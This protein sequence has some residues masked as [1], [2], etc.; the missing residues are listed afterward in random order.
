MTT[1]SNG[2]NPMRYKCDASGCY[3]LKHRPKIEMFAG[4]LPGK[5]AV[6]DVDG[7][8]EV[9]GRFLFLEF[10]SGQPRDIPIGQ[11]IY[12]ERLTSLSPR[13][14]AAVICAD[15]ETMECRAINV[16]RRGRWSGW[17]ITNLQS[18]QE[19]IQA[20]GDHAAAKSRRAA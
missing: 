12:F 16:V 14:T 15:A 7:T 6:T 5:I 13:I 19:R 18:L 20:W 2:Y 3:N 17:E 8:V 4:C 9:N 1:P 10:K 11:R